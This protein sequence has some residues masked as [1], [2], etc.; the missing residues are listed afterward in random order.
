[1]AF[2]VGIRHFGTK[3]KV[4]QR[5]WYISTYGEEEVKPEILPDAESSG[6]S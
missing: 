5:T 6:N 1:M 2:F 4:G 3:E